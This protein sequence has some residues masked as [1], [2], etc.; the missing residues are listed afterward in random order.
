MGSKAVPVLI[1]GLT[2]GLLAGLPY[3]NL[4][5][6]ACCIGI[7]FGGFIAVLLYNRS[8]EKADLKIGSMLGLLSG[9]VGSAI[10]IVLFVV[11]GYIANK[12]SPKGFLAVNHSPTASFASIFSGAS[13]GAEA[14]FWAAF[15]IVPT[16]LVCAGFALL[17]GLIAA[18]IF[19]KRK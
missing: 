17:G 8:G 19:K 5:N 7:A 3:L 10:A 2:V 12:I 4:L 18:A 16:I 6:L 1:G 14:V 15:V 9:L 11:T 13:K